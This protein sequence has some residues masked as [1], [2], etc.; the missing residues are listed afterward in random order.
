MDATRRVRNLP[1]QASGGKIFSRANRSPGTRAK[2]HVTV[3]QGAAVGNFPAGAQSFGQRLNAHNFAGFA[4]GMDL[5]G[6]AAHLAIRRK[7]LAGEARI[8]R[9]IK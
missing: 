8:H 1:I 5:E 2:P 3:A 9:H 7:T 4:F 6:P